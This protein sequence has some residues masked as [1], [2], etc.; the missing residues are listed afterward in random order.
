MMAEQDERPRSLEELGLTAQ[1]AEAMSAEEVLRWALHRFGR[2]I[3]LSTAFGPE[4]MVLID[5]LSRIDPT[6]RVFTID[7]LRLPTE[8]Y[9]LMDRVRELYGIQLEVYY[10]QMHNVER[11][12]TQ[13]GF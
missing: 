8:T 13:Y 1:D 12:T 7:T 5:M 3:A 10:P 11:L 4:G 6:A 2:R 9:A